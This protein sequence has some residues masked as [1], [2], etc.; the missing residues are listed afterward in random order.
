MTQTEDEAH[1][2]RPNVRKVKPFN[3][4]WAELAGKT[5]IDKDVECQEQ[6]A[7]QSRLTSGH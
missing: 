3:S 2:Q 1:E 6:V 4:N 5:E 7:L